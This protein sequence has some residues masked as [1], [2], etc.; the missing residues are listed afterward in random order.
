MNAVSSMHISK[1]VDY[2][3]H[4]QAYQLQKGL[5]SLGTFFVEPDLKQ[6]IVCMSGRCC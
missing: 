6:I 2:T 4:I 3:M 1:V 5:P